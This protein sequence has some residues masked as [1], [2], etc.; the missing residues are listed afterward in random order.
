[1]KV[2][3]VCRKIY[4][5]I[6]YDL[7]EIAFPSSL[8]DP[9]H[10]KKRRKLTWNDRIWV[11]KRASRLYA[12]SWVRDIGPDLRPDDY[13]KGDMTDETYAEKRTA[14]GKEPSTLEDL[15]VAARGGMETLRPALQRVYMT[16]ASAYRDALK[17]FIEGYQEGVQQ[18]M[19]KK[20]DSKTQEDA[21]LPPKKPT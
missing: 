19:E 15:A 11:L 4:D 8:P 3:V 21:D 1:M 10:M 16:R 6:R 5:Y 14:K 12:A 7:K 17:S 20:E 18:V 2:R 13:P 9:P